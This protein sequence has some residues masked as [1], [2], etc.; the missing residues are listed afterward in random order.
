MSDPAAD[1]AASQALLARVAAGEAEPQTRLYRPAR[2]VAFGRLDALTPGYERA[3]EAARA[4]GFA[5]VLRSVGGHAAA[6]TEESLVYERF[7]RERDI[8][9]GIRARFEQVAEHIAGALRS[10]GVDA[11][12]GALPGE[13]CAGEFSVNGPPAG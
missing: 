12:V 2:A 13:Y 11:R 3:R 7:V 4:R 8:A 9:T 6:F 10:L 5:P 1:I